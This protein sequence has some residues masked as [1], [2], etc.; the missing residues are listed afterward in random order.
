MQLG[1]V[2]IGKQMS[3]QQIAAEVLM[4]R[5]ASFRANLQTAESNRFQQIATNNENANAIARVEFDGLVQALSTANVHVHV[6]EDAAEAH[7]PDALFPNN[8]VSFHADGSVVLYPMLAENRRRERRMDILES[9]AKAH[10][11]VIRRLVDLSYRERQEKYLEGTG[12]L[13]LDRVNHIAYAC[14]SPRTNLEVLD[15]F[16][17][18]M[19]YEI[20]AFEATDRSGVP[21][22]HTNVLMS[23]G[24]QFAA[25]CT[26][27]IRADQRAAVLAALGSTHPHLI[28]LTHAQMNEFAGN[29]LELAT[30]TGGQ[31][32][33]LSSRAAAA[34]TSAQRDYLQEHSGP[35]AIAPIATIETLGG[36]SVRCML[37]EIHLPRNEPT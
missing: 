12:S 8:W 26:E 6:F 37:A 9:L 32:V 3:E 14:V 7:C 4:I 24:T 36:G 15:E 2:V 20:I 5:P 11:F 16:A 29:M 25:V 22:Y 10:N 19:N 34:L 13:V 18:S 27:A 31:V 21:V 33:A 30:T 28:E 17:Q 1:E 35:L 23:I